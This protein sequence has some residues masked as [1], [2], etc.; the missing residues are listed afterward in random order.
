M[1]R[2]FASDAFSK[3]P[4]YTTS[5]FPLFYAALGKPFAPRYDEALR[6]LLIHGQAEDGYGY[7]GIQKSGSISRVSFGT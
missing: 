1:D 3:L 2:F 4:W 6:G 7:F 5:F